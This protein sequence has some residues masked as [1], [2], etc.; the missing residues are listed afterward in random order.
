MTFAD[1]AAVSSVGAD[2]DRTVREKLKARYPDGLSYELDTKWESLKNVLELY[3]T[4]LFLGML[5]GAVCLFATILII[6]Y[7]QISEGYEDRRRFQIM[8]KIGMEERAVKRTI[9]S[10]LVMQ[11]FLPLI[12]LLRNAAQGSI[13][14]RQQLAIMRQQNE[15]VEDFTRQLN[16]FKSKFS[17]N[18][19]DATNRFNDAIREIDETIKHLQ[20]V[21]DALLLSGK[22]LN[23]ANSKV[24][25]LTIKRLTKGNPTM[26]GKFEAAGIEIE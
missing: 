12:S 16:D 18:Y 21:R 1:E 26:T 22:H 23:S 15:D 8:Q 17:R 13:R 2:F 3:G 5:L 19:Q 25:D 9:G 10:Q 20:K 11:F 24:E 4:F 14:Y 6:Y 7:K